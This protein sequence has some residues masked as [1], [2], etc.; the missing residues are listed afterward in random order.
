MPATALRCRACETDHPSSRPASAPAARF[1]TRSTTWSGWPGPSRASDRRGTAVV[2]RYAALLPSAAPAE[3]RLAPG[4]TPLVRGA[5]LA[6]Q[7]GPRRALA[8]ARH[9]EPDPLVQGPG[10]GGRDGEGAEFGLT[11]LACSSTGNLANAVAA[12]AAAEGLEAAVFFPADLEPEKLTRDRRLRRDAVRGRRHVRRLHPPNV[13]LSFE[14]PW[15]FVNTDLRATTRRGRRRSPTR[16]PSSSA[17]SPDVV[18]APSRPARCTP[19]FPRGSPT[20]SRSAWSTGRNPS[21]RRRPGEGVRAGRTA[22]AAEAR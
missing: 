10:G 7:L 19:S 12:R 5:R 2:W 6:E 14:L 3:P 9:G 11:T 17:G 1:L 21:P 13:E 18:V 8:E 4:L 16:S 22:F 20:C 15:A